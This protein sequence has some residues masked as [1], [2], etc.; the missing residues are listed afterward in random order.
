MRPSGRRRPADNLTNKRNRKSGVS[1]CNRA[2]SAG[3][4]DQGRPRCPNAPAGGHG[5]AQERLF[6]ERGTQHYPGRLVDVSGV[7]R[8]VTS[9]INARKRGHR[10][11]F[12]LSVG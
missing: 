6:G 1:P 5:R 7:D 12:W 3:H 11:A 10:C 8:P 9:R 4:V 2:R